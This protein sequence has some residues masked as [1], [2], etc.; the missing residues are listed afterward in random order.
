VDIRKKLVIGTVTLVALG[1]LG[2]TAAMAKSKAPAKAPRIAA[3][4]PIPTTD[5]DTLQ[6]GDQST[7]D[8]TALAAVSSSKGSVA[9][10]SKSTSPAENSGEGE[11][12][13]EGESQGES[14]GPGGHADAPGNVDY[15]FDGEQ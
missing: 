12:Q 6:E 13:G 15:Q 4:E 9:P 11:N 3:S 8:G 2:S 1:G 14:D 7:P 10:S 5:P